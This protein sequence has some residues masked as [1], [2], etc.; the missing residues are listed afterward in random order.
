MRKAL[1]IVTAALIAL[2]AYHLVPR[3]VPPQTKKPLLIAHRGV[4]QNHQLDGLK[5]D[6]CT[7]TLIEPPRHEYIENTIPSIA[8][9]FEAGADMVEVDIHPTTDGRLAIFHD[10][11]LDCRT[12][13]RGVT[14]EQSFTY[15]KTLDVGHGYTADG[16]Q[17]FP[18]RG[19]GIGL[20]PSLD[21]VLT[22]FPDKQLLI[23]QKDHYRKTLDLL[24]ATINGLP[25]ERREQLFYWN[26]QRDFNALS[27][28]TSGI[29]KLVPSRPEIKACAKA[30]LLRL[31]LGALPR[32]CAT[33][34]A[35]PARYRDRIP[36]WPGLL[37]Q[38]AKASNIP[39][40]V[41]DVDTEADANAVKDLP[42]DG[43]M[44]NRIEVVGP[45]LR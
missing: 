19:K 11:T 7:A 2:A 29:R 28:R 36:G 30:Y 8:A 38:K 34:L 3:S 9:A 13:G 32:Q 40:F 26:D 1:L 24:A 25:P 35:F 12:N 10:W 41:L 6:T 14:H 18:L 44:T 39:V 43:I 33:G 21:E 22:E 27:Q 31:G 45:L 20:M 4:H 23:D 15:L 16:G 42:L 5:N 37:L 17:T